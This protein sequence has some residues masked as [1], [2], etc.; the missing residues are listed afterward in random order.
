MRSIDEYDG[1]VVS[2]GLMV[3]TLDAV[4]HAEQ[5]EAEHRRRFRRIW[6]LLE[7]VYAAAVERTPPALTESDTEFLAE[8]LASMRQLVVDAN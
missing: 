3:N 4:W 5:W 1:T 8:T 6:G 2:L 7:Q